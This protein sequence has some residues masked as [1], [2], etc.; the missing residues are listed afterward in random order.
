VLPLRL[1]IITPETG[2]P[3]SKLGYFNTRSKKVRITASKD[4]LTASHELTH[5]L[6]NRH[7]IVQ[8]ILSGDKKYAKLKPLLQQ[9]YLRWYPGAKKNHSL[10]T[11]LSEGLAVLVEHYILDSSVMMTNYED[12]VNEVFGK[13]GVLADLKG[14]GQEN[15]FQNE[16]ND[17]VAE[18]RKIAEKYQSLSSLEK[19]KQPLLSMKRNLKDKDKSSGSFWNKSEFRI[20]N[21][22]EPARRWSKRETL[23]QRFYYALKVDKSLQNMNT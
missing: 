22:Y 9:Q 13:D 12:A 3:S 8:K 2:V 1:S 17:V 4:V 5:A 7:G 21:M 14:E 10:E 19:M 15:A 18:I 23:R 6:D 11:Q 16:I 20:L